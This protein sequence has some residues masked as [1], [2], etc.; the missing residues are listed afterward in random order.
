[1][2]YSTSYASRYHALT[3]EGHRA[4]DTYR[5]ALI[6][7]GAHLGENDHPGTNVWEAIFGGPDP[8]KDPVSKA[9]FNAARQTPRY[10]EWLADEMNGSMFDDSFGDVMERSATSFMCSAFGNFMA[11]RVLVELGER[12]ALALNKA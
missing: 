11:E 2:S 9:A 7:D 12:A 4:I 8:Q 10:A 5:D 3:D 6:A 1:M